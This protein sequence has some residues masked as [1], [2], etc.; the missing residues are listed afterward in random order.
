MT[1]G[2]SG[3][4]QARTNTGEDHSSPPAVILCTLYE[5]KVGGCWTYE[6]SSSLESNR[7]RVTDLPLED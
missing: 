6:R 2:G 1:R 4:V 3:T 5:A 7:K